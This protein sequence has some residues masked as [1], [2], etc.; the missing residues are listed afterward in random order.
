MTQS[1]EEQNTQ[2]AATSSTN[3]PA[4]A[5]G[6]FVKTGNQ[7]VQLD[8]E[9]APFL[10]EEEKKEESTD[11]ATTE[12]NSDKTA[13]DDEDQEPKSKKKLIIIAGAALVLILAI[14]A[15]AF[16]FLF[17]EKEV[18]ILQ[19]IIV[20]PNPP[21]EEIP[22]FYQIKLDPIWI[23]LKNRDDGVNFLVGTFILSM[24]TKSIQNEIEKN[25]KV[26]RDAVYYYLINTRPEFLMDHENTEKIKA[27]ISDI[28]NR[29]VVS[30]AV[31]EIY[32]DSFLMK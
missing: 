4:E 1:A 16:F 32:F 28:V 27:G 25:I 13:K 21:T 3:A 19:N 11:L 30:G 5:G 8:L 29:Y 20:V 26:V 23:E 7:K 15:G 14:S 22:L 2:I 17:A 18:I 12:P 10:Q 31:D 6:K 24:E 9:D